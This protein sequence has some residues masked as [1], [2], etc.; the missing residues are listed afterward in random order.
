MT[1]L[2]FF[3]SI[4][5]LFLILVALYLDLPESIFNIGFCFFLLLRVSETK[6]KSLTTAMGKMYMGTCYV[7]LK[8]LISGES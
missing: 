5:P 6:N 3:F 7:L 8:V 1:L 4:K 2:Y